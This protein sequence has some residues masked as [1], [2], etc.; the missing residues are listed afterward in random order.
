MKIIKSIIRRVPR[1]VKVTLNLSLFILLLLMGYIF[2]GCP[3]FSPQQQFRRAEKAN[4]SGPAENLDTVS[5]EGASYLYP[6]NELIIGQSGDGVT[7]F[8]YNSADL[9]QNAFTYREKTD[10][11]MV[12]AVPGKTFEPKYLG[13][14]PIVLFDGI[15]EAVYAELDVELK[16]RYDHLDSLKVYKL[17][18]NRK[19]DGYFLF[20]LFTEDAAQRHAVWLLTQICSDEGYGRYSEVAVPVTARFYDREGNLLRQT[21]MKI[22]SLSGLQKSNRLS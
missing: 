15:K 13:C 22:Q 11:I 10:D 1:S 18:A 16:L 7:L 14:V 2:C 12:I 21:T 20:S 3:A 9:K 6:Y 8:C 17:K 4:L 19:T 5:L